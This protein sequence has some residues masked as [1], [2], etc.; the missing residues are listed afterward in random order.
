MLFETN[1]FREVWFECKRRQEVHFNGVIDSCVICGPYIGDCEETSEMS[2]RVIWYPAFRFSIYFQDIFLS[3]RR[4]QHLP[5][6][7]WQQAVYQITRRDI[8]KSA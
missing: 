1:T 5:P 8:Q 3:R 4:R 7:Y 2:R 6:K